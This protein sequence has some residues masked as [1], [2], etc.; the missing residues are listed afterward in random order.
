MSAI[1]TK[2]I[3][4][5]AI[6]NPKLSQM[7]AHTYKG[8]NTGSTSNA[9]DITNTQLT[10]DLNLFTTSL[11]GLVPASGGGTTNFLR[12]DGTFAAPTGGSGTVTS[13]ALTVPTFLSVAGSPVTTS[14]TLAVTLSGTALPAINGGT[15]QTTYA[16]GDLLYASAS[17]TLSKLTVGSTNQVLTVSGGIPI[18]ASPS[19]SPAA[20]NVVSKTSNYTAVANDYVKVDGSSGAFTV[21]LPTAV[22]ISGQ[23]INIK[24]IDNNLTNRISVVTTSSQTIDTVSTV[25]LATQFEEWIFVSDGANW[26]IQNHRADSPFTSYT[27]TYTGIGTVTNSALIWRRIGDSLEVMGTF[28]NG[29]NAG[30]LASITIPSGLAIDTTKISIGNTTGAPGCMIGTWTSNSSNS[31][32]W[33]I[34]ATATSTSIVYY[35][36]PFAQTGLLTPTNGNAGVGASQVQ[37]VVFRTP[38]TGWEA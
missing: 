23:I 35:G 22:G 33:I 1:K 10:A 8:N 27:P 3:L 25:H 13:I 20:I 9:S 6:T 38:I 18:W 31:S 36:N 32:G 26:S 30:V 17:N 37:S 7:A 15:A 28:T 21:T 4:D 19:S 2:F 29:S 24:R 34:T 16:T 12:A 5:N 14:G 11:Q